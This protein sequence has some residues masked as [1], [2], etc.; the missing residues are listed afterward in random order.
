MNRTADDIEPHV[1][2]NPKIRI[3][4]VHR[5]DGKVWR[6]YVSPTGANRRVRLGWRYLTD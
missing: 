1:L 2:R 5:T 4:T 6:E 3:V